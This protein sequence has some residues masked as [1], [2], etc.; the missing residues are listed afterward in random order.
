MT[1]HLRQML[2]PL[3]LATIFIFSSA[4]VMAQQVTLSAADIDAAI[5]ESLPNGVTMGTATAE[6]LSAAVT[7]VMA[8][9]PGATPSIVARVIQLRPDLATAIV[10]AAVT[11]APQQAVDITLAAIDAAPNQTESI[12]NAAIVATPTQAEAIRKAVEKHQLSQKPVPDNKKIFPPRTEEGTS[13][14]ERD[15]RPASP[16][17]P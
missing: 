5:Q 12:T 2:A 10:T 4:P 16:T 17:M 11:A 3:I 14:P 15:E 13:P 6:Q 9:N 7:Q 1:K 8:A